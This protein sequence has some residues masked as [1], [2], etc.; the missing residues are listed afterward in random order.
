MSER[1]VRDTSAISMRAELHAAGLR[2]TA[3]RVA[4]LRSLHG[5]AGPVSH[6]DVAAVLASE[7]LDRATVYRNLMD[8][9]EAGLLKRTDHGDHTWRFELKSRETSHVEED[10]HPHFMCDAC[11]DVTCLPDA[12][13]HV[14]A[15][16][17]T[18]RAIGKR[19]YEVQI[20]GRCDRCA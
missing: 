9:T 11:G 5:A 19:A 20:K 1:T 7:G 15:A 18:P 17:G 10:P 2:A 3:P 12:A 6:G 4:V 8:L 13:V 14:V 16:R